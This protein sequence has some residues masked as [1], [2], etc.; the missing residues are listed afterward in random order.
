MK[1]KLQQQNRVLVVVGDY[2]GRRGTVWDVRP[3][4]ATDKVIGY[5]YGVNLDAEKGSPS[6]TVTLQEHELEQIDE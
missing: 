3:I 1:P 2:N 6:T 4:K 5:A